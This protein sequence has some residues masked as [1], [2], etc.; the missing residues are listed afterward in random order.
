MQLQQ[1]RY[2][3]T[4]AECGSV[5]AAAQKLYL[6]QSSLSVA[7]RDL[8]RELGITIFKRTSRGV[9]P[10]SAGMEAISYARQIVDQ[11]D[12]MLSRFGP[13]GAAAEVRFAVSSQHYEVVVEAFGD[14]LDAHADRACH[15]TL[16]ETDTVQVMRDVHDHRSS[17]GVIYL[18]DYNEHV[19]GRAIASNDL[20]FRPLFTARPH[21]FVRADCE[22]ARRGSVRP[23][24]LS[25]MTRFAHLQRTEGSAYFAE[26]PL[27]DLP[28][29]SHVALSDNGSLARLLSEHDGYNIATGVYP[30]DRGIVPVPLVTD[31]VMVVG[32]LVR[33]DAAEDGLRE[34]FLDLLA[35]RCAAC[36]PVVKPSDEVL[37]RAGDSGR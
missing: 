15:L 16:C 1:L 22:L 35:A 4:T 5:R 29:R 10:T 25:D 12:L 26:E 30:S 37:R 27:A 32:Y 13:G 2:L 31:E 7:I 18:N 33:Q 21:V 8:E 20:E 14:L 19:V 34:E 23:E 24:E 17:V 3:I 6:S 9:S 36:A 11:A 28:C